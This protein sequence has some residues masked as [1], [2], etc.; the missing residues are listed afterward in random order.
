MCYVIPGDPV[1]L[2]RNNFGNDHGYSTLKELRTITTITLQNQ[3]GEL[4][5]FRGPLCIRMNFY[6]DFSPRF[7]KQFEGDPHKASPNLYS[8]IKFIC[9]VSTGILYEDDRIVANI[10]AY[11]W[12]SHQPRT[13]FTISEIVL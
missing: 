4:G 12:Y 10:L 3:H 13:E 2:A 1:G 6:L 5:F 11:K 7:T 8:M 9:D